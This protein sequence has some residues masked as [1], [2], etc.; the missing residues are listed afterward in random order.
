MKPRIFQ[1]KKGTRVV[2]FSE[3]F[4]ALKLPYHYYNRCLKDWLSDY[5]SFTDDVRIP[6]EMQDYSE[7]PQP[8]SPY[9]DYYLTLELARLMTLNSKSPLKKE[10]AR[11]LMIEE[12]LN[13]GKKPLAIG[14]N[15][16]A[17][18]LKQ[19]PQLSLF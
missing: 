5:Y 11:W 10:L 16:H 18:L 15:I 14:M 7:R 3:L 4:S 1:S 13:G 19:D 2:R 6:T 8:F 9:K 12:Q 17:M